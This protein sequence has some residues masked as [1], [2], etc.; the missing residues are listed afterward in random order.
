MNI[1]SLAKRRPVQLT[2]ASMIAAVAVMITFF[3]AQP[4]QGD[5]TPRVM[6]FDIVE[7]GSRF[8]FDQTHLDADGLPAYGNVFTTQGY[9]YPAGTITVDNGA[10]TGVN[11]DGSPEFP[12]QVIGTWTCYGTH[13]GQGA[14][15]KTGPWV[16]TTQ[17]YDFGEKAGDIS[18]VT[19]GV[20][21]VD[22]DVPVD[23]AVTGATGVSDLVG[24]R[25]AQAMIG[26][27]QSQGVALRVRFSN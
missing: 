26:F 25:Q 12:D 4:T 21:I 27:N 2:T 13:V 23:R 1:V 15:T 9:I 3:A 7:D 11:A 14:K 8:V 6:A 22:L 18:I 17:I 5:A 19:S 16:A 20:E 10:A 24:G